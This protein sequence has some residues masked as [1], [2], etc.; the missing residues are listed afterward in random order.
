MALDP[1]EIL[2]Q[3]EENNLNQSNQEVNIMNQTSSSLTNTDVD[4][5][6]IDSRNLTEIESLLD[7]AETA[8]EKKS[9][10][11]WSISWTY[12]VMLSNQLAYIE[13][14][15]IQADDEG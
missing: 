7:K 4:M 1:C 9:P 6:D 12:A 5:N 15:G 14:L 2:M 10:L 13:R 3:L 8:A 11:L